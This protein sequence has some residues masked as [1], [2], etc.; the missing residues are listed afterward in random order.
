MATVTAPSSPT[1]VITLVS[2]S[3]TDAST[4]TPIEPSPMV[5]TVTTGITVNYRAPMYFPPAPESVSNTDPKQASG[6][7]IRAMYGMVITPTRAPIIVDGK[8]T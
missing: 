6:V 8:A 5:T 2:V 4:V 1:G 7:L 3:I